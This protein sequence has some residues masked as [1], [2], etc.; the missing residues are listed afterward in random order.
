MDYDELSRCLEEFSCV[1]DRQACPGCGTT[2][3]SVLKRGVTGCPE[4]FNVFR[5]DLL[6]ILQG[7]PE[8][9]RNL[10]IRIDSLR[11]NLEGLVKQENYE[12]AV[13]LRDKINKLKEQLNCNPE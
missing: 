1:M 12:A 9:R 5:D 3:E 2:R 7:E 4:C 6:S 8:E 11:Q 13:E 10:R